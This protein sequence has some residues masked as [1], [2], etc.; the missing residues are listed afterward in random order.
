MVNVS[1]FLSASFDF[2]HANGCYWWGI[3]DQLEFDVFLLC[4]FAA[5]E[6]L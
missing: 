2:L 4:D 3:I 1:V 6:A 5:A